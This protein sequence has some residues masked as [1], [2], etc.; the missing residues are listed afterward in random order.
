[1]AE[2]IRLAEM[3]KGKA[4][5]TLSKTERIY[6]DDNHHYENIERM[7]SVLSIAYMDVDVYCRKMGYHPPKQVKAKPKQ[8]AKSDIFDVDTYNPFSI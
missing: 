3:P 1:M 8:M 7:A 4:F 5:K 6:I 2:F